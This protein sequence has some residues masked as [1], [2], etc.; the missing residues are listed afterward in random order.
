M[1]TN[2]R[3]RLPVACVH[4]FSELEDLL[5]QQFKRRWPVPATPKIGPSFSGSERNG[6]V[7]WTGRPDSDSAHGEIVSWLQDCGMGFLSPPITLVHA[8]HEPELPC[9]EAA[10]TRLSNQQ[11]DRCLKC[12][13]LSPNGL[14]PCEA[15]EERRG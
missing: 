4:K 6:V 3:G 14:T 15:C 9:A 11:A 7:Q 10:A 2:S 12:G 1:T 8:D 5:A 13:Q